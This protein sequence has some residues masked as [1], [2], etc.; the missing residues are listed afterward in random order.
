MNDPIKNEFFFFK[1]EIH[2]MN[3]IIDSTHQLIEDL[4]DSFIDI[5]REREKTNIELKENLAKNYSLRRTDFDQM[6]NGFLALQEESEGEIRNLLK[7]YLTEQKELSQ[8]L[9]ENIDKFYN[10]C[11]KGESPEVSEMNSLI[12]QILSKQK[13]RKEDVTY[14]LKE[15]QKEQQNFTSKFKELLIKG[16]ELRMRDFKMMLKEFKIQREKRLTL[17][18]ERKEDV[19]KML[20]EFKK[21]RQKAALHLRITIDGTKEKKLSEAPLKS[22]EQDRNSD[23]LKL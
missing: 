8:T 17:Q 1:N 2:N 7:I 18:R 21:D 16:K 23:V 5:K 10:A 6:V 11:I 22:F 20:S 13:E 12:H 14:K 9:I 3:S 4:Q 15:F 19:S